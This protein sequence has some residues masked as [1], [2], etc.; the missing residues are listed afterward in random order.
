MLMLAAVNAK[1]NPELN[2]QGLCH[3]DEI[4]SYQARYSTYFFRDCVGICRLGS[5][6]SSQRQ[7]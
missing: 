6:T 4:R 1:R 2:E 3:G 7:S 5:M